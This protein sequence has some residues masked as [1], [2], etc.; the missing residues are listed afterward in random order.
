MQALGSC[1]PLLT[2]THQ[3]GPCPSSKVVTS[4]QPL[5]FTCVGSS[6]HLWNLPDKIQTS[7]LHTSLQDLGQVT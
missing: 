6:A 4:K 3:A 1:L 2:L 5:G 7:I